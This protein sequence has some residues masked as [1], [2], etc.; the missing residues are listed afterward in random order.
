[1]NNS[2]HNRA[3]AFTLLEVL[4]ATA[5]IGI[6]SLMM[7]SSLYISVKAKTSSVEALSPHNDVAAVF[8]FMR[9]DIE[10]AINPGGVLAGDFVGEDESCG[11]SQD[12]DTIS[13]YTTS[14]RT[15]DE[16]SGSNIV[17]VEYILE[18]DQS[19][20]EINLTDYDD[21]LTV[22]KRNITRNLLAATTA[23]PAAEVISRNITGINLR[24]YNGS[25]WQEQWNSQQ[26]DNTLP[27]AVEI[28]L[29]LNKKAGNAETEIAAYTKI[30]MTDCYKPAQASSNEQQ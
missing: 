1:M 23:A 19:Q 15:S 25:D 16:Q 11:D 27:Q 30:V 18:A 3:E 22:L 6:L 10:C 13:L 12:C 14:A 26:E 21:S 8:D 29:T 4:L 5:I 17:K 7:Y 28:T 9:R 24:Y 20:P 2:K